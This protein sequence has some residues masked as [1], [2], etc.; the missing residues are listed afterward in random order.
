MQQ[1]HE[2]AEIPRATR[3]NG[4]KDRATRDIR[5]KGSD[6]PVETREHHVERIRKLTCLINVKQ[7]FQTKFL[8]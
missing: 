6:T 5:N 3:W 4:T 1:R 8:S 2:P 7:V